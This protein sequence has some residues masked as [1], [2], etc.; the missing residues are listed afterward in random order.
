[1]DFFAIDV[2]AELQRGMPAV[3]ADSVGKKSKLQ[4]SFLP[5]LLDFQAD[6]SEDLF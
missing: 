6:V 5:G 1:M 3:P 2:I 4:V